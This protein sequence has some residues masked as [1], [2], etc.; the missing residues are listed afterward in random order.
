MLHLYLL[1][2]LLNILGFNLMLL[3]QN[4]TFLRIIFLIFQKICLYTYL[5]TL[6]MILFYI[7]ILFLQ[8]YLLIL[9]PLLEGLLEFLNLLHISNPINAVQFLLGIPF[10]ILFLLNI[11]HLIILTSTIVFLHLRNFSFIIKLLVILTRKL[12]WQQKLMH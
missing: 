6:L 8:P 5:M 7:L 4:L 2:I 11:C 10:L 1:M 12:L 3:V 9:F